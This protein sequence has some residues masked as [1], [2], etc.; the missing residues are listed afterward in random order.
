MELCPTLAYSFVVPYT[1]LRRKTSLKNT[2]GGGELISWGTVTPSC[3]PDSR[4]VGTVTIDVLL[5]CMWSYANRDIAPPCRMNKFPFIQYSR[6]PLI[7]QLVIRISNYP[8]RFG[9]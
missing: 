5:D 7:R 2:V 6:T 3:D 1:E 8:E 9:L 4:S